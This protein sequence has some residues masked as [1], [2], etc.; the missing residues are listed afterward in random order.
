MK[1]LQINN[2]H[3][4]RGGADVV[5]LNTGNL[6]VE[7]G[8][9]VVYFSTENQNNAESSYSEYFI[10][11]KDIRD[12]NFIRKIISSKDYIF[13]K[14][15]YQNLNSLLKI[16]KPDVAHVHLFYGYFHSTGRVR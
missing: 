7:N 9:E 6:L 4:R 15:A 8:H 10:S 14:K 3:F 11:I 12:Q 16:H 1:I 13:N 2:C 5:Y